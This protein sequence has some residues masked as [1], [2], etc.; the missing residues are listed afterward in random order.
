MI[1][2]QIIIMSFYYMLAHTSKIYILMHMKTLG[3]LNFPLIPRQSLEEFY[4]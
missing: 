1:Q 2:Q 3:F 4:D